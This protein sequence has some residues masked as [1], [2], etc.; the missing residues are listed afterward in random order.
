MN[1]TAE[2]N[3]TDAL[4]EQP[5]QQQ[6]TVTLDTPIQHG[7]K[8]VKEVTVRKP[9]SGALRGA[10]LSDL[11]RMDVDAVTKILPRITTP[12]LTEADIRSM[13]PADL[14]ELSSKVANFL[15]PKR[16]RGADD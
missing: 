1:D 7:S 11:I 9:L 4:P 10:N 16:L 6:A 12:S 5:A 8:T 15:L 14:F 2:K 3:A 13:D